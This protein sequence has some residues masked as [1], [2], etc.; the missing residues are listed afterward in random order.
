MA[1]VDLDFKA[2]LR[3]T[4]DALK[5]TI[6]L[7]DAALKQEL[8]SPKWAWPVGSSPRDIVDSGRLRAAQEL[9]QS[10]PS[11]WII[12]WPVGYAIYVHE[13]YTTRSGST[14]PARRWTEAPLAQI[15]A[16]YNAALKARLDRL[17]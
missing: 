6:L 17:P 10:S 11:E 16:R 2:V 5:D 8:S 15:Q 7:T 3:A 13:G 1:K 14:M 12:R 4:Q 9:I